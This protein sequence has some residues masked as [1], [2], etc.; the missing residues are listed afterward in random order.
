MFMSKD[1]CITFVLAQNC[2][3]P[4]QYSSKISC[5]HLLSKTG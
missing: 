4:V 2:N 3:V 5:V 1:K